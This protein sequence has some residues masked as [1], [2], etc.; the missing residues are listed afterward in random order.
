MCDSSKIEINEQTAVWVLLKY[1]INFFAKY[2]IFIEMFPLLD[3]DNVVY[4]NFRMEYKYTHVHIYTYIYIYI[5][6]YI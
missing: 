2:C 1:N 4:V 6:I 3:L 5:Y